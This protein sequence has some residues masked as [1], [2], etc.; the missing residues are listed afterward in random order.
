MQ[1]QYIKS[2]VRFSFGQFSFSLVFAGTGEAKHAV[3]AEVEKS[4]QEL[5]E[6]LM[7]VTGELHDLQDRY[8][9]QL[10]DNAQLSR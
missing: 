3:I 4:R 5:E 1:K 9:A 7:A 6:R 8:Q 10:N 2:G